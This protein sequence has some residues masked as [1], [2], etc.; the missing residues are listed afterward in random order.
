MPDI[1]V[2]NHGSILV[3]SGVS[4]AGKSWLN[5]NVIEPNSEV[6]MWGGG[7]VVEPRYV[8]HIVDGARNDGLEVE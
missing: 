5:D 6:Q 1:N 3:L 8:D 4:E 7:V 2:Q